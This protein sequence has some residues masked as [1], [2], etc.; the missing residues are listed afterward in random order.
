MALAFS[1]REIEAELRRLDTDLCRQSSRANLIE[2]PEIVIAHCN[3]S[4]GTGDGLTELRED[5]PASAPGD[6][7]ARF[8]SVIGVFARHELPR[9][10]LHELAAQCEVVERLASGGREQ[11]R[12][13]ERHRKAAN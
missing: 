3:R 11:D 4:L 9:R 7:G 13:S 10:A 5:Q 2:E 6:C 8:E 1:E 12:T